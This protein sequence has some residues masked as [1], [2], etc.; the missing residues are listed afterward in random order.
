KAHI[1]IKIK[2]ANNGD[3]FIEFEPHND[4]TRFYL[5]EQLLPTLVPGLEKLLRIANDDYKIRMEDDL[6]FNPLLWLASY[7]MR[8]N[9]KYNPEAK[10]HPYVKLL[11]NHVENIRKDVEEEIKRKN[12]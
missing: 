11:L 1:K 8:N 12:I 3:S 4:E 9:P 7:L 10:N 6:P 2:S 5:E